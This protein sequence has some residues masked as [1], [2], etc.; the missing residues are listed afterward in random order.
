MGGLY[1]NIGMG[2]WRVS[3]GSQLPES[4]LANG[5]DLSKSKRQ[6]QFQCQMK[7]K[8]R[9]FNPSTHFTKLTPNTICTYLYNFYHNSVP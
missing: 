2:R 3:W 8:T 4:G 5:P 9:W 7:A 1:R 6:V